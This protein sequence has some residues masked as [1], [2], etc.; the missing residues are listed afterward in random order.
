MISRKL[1]L[2]IAI[3]ATLAGGTFIVDR[4]ASGVEARAN[5]AFPPEGQIITVDG[6]A[7][8]A[9]VAGTGPDL[10]LIHGASGNLRDFTFSLIPKLTDRYR[11][12][13][14]DRP[15]LGWSDPLP[16]GNTN[17]AAQAA[18]LRR[19]ADQLGVQNPIVLGH[20]YGGA[21]AIAWALDNPDTG[22]LVLVAAASMPWEGSIWYM[23]NVMGS[24]IGG[25]TAVPLIAAF[26]GDATAESATRDIFQPDAMPQGYLAH[27]GA[28]L[29]MRRTTLQANSAQ[30]AGLKPFIIAM[31]ARYAELTLPVEAVHGDTDV[32]VPLRV[33]S[34]PLSD[35]LPN[36]HLTVLPGTGH[37]PHHADEPQVLAAIDR[38][39]ARAASTAGL[40]PAP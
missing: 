19:A 14:F 15:G 24:T 7:V 18:H 35:L 25:W 3:L 1:A 39:A 11:V 8:H 30:V 12:I 13:A 28:S 16:E 34:G 5:A 29:T 31:R 9:Y 22:A 6:L 23:H 40:R 21:V 38:A 33:H 36:V 17:P 4:R 26:A 32:I 20:S 10:I 2:S 37:M 27:I